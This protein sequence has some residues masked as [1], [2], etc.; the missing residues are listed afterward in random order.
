MAIGDSRFLGLLGCGTL[1]A[2]FEEGLEDGV[3]L[4]V[5]VVNDV[6]QVISV[7]ELRN[8][9]ASLRV[10]LVQFGPLAT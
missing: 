1:G 10:G 8:G 9:L 4:L 5:V 6:H 7:H 3:G 2:G